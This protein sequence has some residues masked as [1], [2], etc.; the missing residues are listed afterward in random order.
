MVAVIG[1]ASRSVALVVV[2]ATL[3]GAAIVGARVLTRSESCCRGQ[4]P[5]I[6][7]YNRP[8]SRVDRVLAEGDG[9]AFGAIAQ[10]PLLDR[11]Q[12]IGSRAEYAYRAQRPLWAYLAWAG[13]L[14]QAGLT[15]WVLAVLTVLSCGAA[16]MLFGLLLR[17]R[18]VSVWW[19]LLVPVIGLQ[20][21]TE[22]T[23]E[24]AAVA[25][26]CAG[27]LL[28]SRE[29]RGAAVVMLSLA[30]L[31]RESML[32]GVVGLGVW[33]LHR[34]A[35]TGPRLRRASLLAWPFGVYGAWIAILTIRL[36]VSPF[37]RSGGR[38]GL[39]GA[40]LVAT[41]AGGS[42]VATAVSVASG[43]VRCSV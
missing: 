14:G 36:G 19:S 5:Y 29:R 35:G 33:E 22:F 34:S 38:L 30:A 40:G 1:R 41:L 15:G 17:Q 11:P 9:Q 28:W 18:G 3:L 39:P 37:A 23:S 26:L 10:D 2:A 43:S 12:V 27:I 20:V 13:S 6:S 4:H 21:L 32:V 7:L 16:S 25:L 8:L 24:L 42:S 31:T